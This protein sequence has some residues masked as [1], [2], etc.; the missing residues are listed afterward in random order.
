MSLQKHGLGSAETVNPQGAKGAKLGWQGVFT[1][2]F[3]ITTAL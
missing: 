3:Q 1:S 2:N